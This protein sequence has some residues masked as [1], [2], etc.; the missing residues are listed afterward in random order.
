MD[1]QTALIGYINDGVLSGKTPE[2][3]RKT[4]YALEYFFDYL[5]KEFRPLTLE[6]LSKENIEGF[7]IYGIQ[8]KKWSRFTHITYY[9][10]LHAFG[11]WLVRKKHIES[12]PMVDVPKPKQPPRFPK[13]MTELETIELLQAVAKLP[14]SY[15]FTKTRNKAIIAALIF[16]GLRK[17]ELLDLKVRDVDLV[18]NLIFVE[19]GKGQKSREVPIETTILK[20]IL[21]EYMEYRERL[22]RADNY[23]FNGQW[24]GVRVKNKMSYTVLDRLFRDLSKLLKKRVHAHKLRH[25]FATLVL[26]R[27]G[28]VYTLQQLMGHTNIATTTIY[29]NSTRRKKVEA[30]GTLN[31]LKKTSEIS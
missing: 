4:S 22:G 31:L 27:T 7:F 9:I 8:Q 15:G 16:T 12:N 21:V 30:I 24:A 23:F 2:T 3:L 28:D 29:L 14:T 26:D 18:N 10:K 20:P 11:N 5:T 6:E 17:S 1:L 25:T 19:M 13:S